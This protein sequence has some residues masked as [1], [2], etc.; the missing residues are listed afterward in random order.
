MA[1]DFKGKN[2]YI[3]GGSSGIGLSTAKQLAARGAN[4]LIF[5]RTEERLKASVEMCIRDREIRSAIGTAR[6]G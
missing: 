5:A 2:A 4:V 3:T 6:V 1:A